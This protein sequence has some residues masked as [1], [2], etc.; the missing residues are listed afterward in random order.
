MT[1]SDPLGHV[2]G[3]MRLIAPGGAAGSKTLVDLAGPPWRVDAARAAAAAGLDPEGTWDIATLVTRASTTGSGTRLSLA[4][5]HG[6]VQVARV[7]A[8]ASFTA[9]LDERVRR[10]LNGFGAVTRTLPGARTAPYLGS[11][12][13]TPVY[14]DMPSTMDAQRRDVPDSYRLVSLGVGLDG[15]SVPPPSHF[16]LRPLEQPVAIDL[17]TPAPSAARAAG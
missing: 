14:L 3:A 11:A 5:V 9:V 15:V 7:N 4:L 17:R 8:A 12:A 16:R 13:S 6:L 10:L 2:L 1:V